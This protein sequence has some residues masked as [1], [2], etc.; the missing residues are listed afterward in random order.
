MKLTSLRPI[1]WTDLFEA[2]I[3]FYTNVL[4][5][6]FAE[7]NDDWAWA[8][9]Y[10]DSVEIMIA[11]PNQHTPFDKPKFTGSFYFN[12]D[13]VETLWIQLKDNVKICYALETFEWGM[14]E[15]AFYDNNG[16]ILQFGQEV[17]N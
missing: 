2:T 8:S 12:T 17:E 9:L 7:R 14:R 15:F 13:D 5:F 4:G 6:S 10:K 1:I 16:Y 3:K 11:L